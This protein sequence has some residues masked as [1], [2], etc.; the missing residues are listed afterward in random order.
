M[1]S[2]VNHAALHAW[3]A[4]S[5]SIVLTISVALVT[6]TLR[7]HRDDARTAEQL[8]VAVA[9]LAALCAGPVLLAAAVLLPDTWLWR[10]LRAGDERLRL[11]DALGAAVR[12]RFWEALA[13]AP[14]LPWRPQ[15]L[16]SLARPAKSAAASVGNAKDAAAASVGNAK[17]ASGEAAAG[18]VLA[19][20]ATSDWAGSRLQRLPD[21]GVGGGGG[22]GSTTAARPHGAAAARVPPPPSLT[23]RQRSVL[24][25]LTAGVAIAGDLPL[26]ATSIA[27]VMLA[28]DSLPSATAVDAAA[29]ASGGGGGASTSANSVTMNV[30]LPALSVLLSLWHLC[31][32]LVVV[33]GTGEG[34]SSAAGAKLFST[35]GLP[36][37]HLASAQEEGEGGAV[38]G[39]SGRFHVREQLREAGSLAQPTTAPARGAARQQRLRDPEIEGSERG[40]ELR[41]PD[42][43]DVGSSGGGSS[44][45]DS[46]QELSW[47]PRRHR[48]ATQLGIDGAG[49]SASPARLPRSPARAHDGGDEGATELRQGGQGQQHMLHSNAAAPPAAVETRNPLQQSQPQSQQ[50]PLAVEAAVLAVVEELRRTAAHSAAPRGGASS[51]AGAAAAAAAATGSSGGHGTFQRISEL[52]VRAATPEARRLAAMATFWSMH[53]A[54]LPAVS[55]A[56][57]QTPLPRVWLRLLHAL[58]ADAQQHGQRV[59][60]GATMESSSASSSGSGVDDSGADSELPPLSSSFGS[61][62]DSGYSSSLL[63]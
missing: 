45:S 9:A 19:H 20:D 44:Y 21:R 43:P 63:A 17:D 48:P 13:L 30:L 51:A 53:P 59:A 5:T 50:P 62:S 16:V 42:S 26:A 33:V 11:R 12:Y 39:D 23:L 35:G 38:A 10:R 2:V 49:R 15:L 57:A 36:A 55:D 29:A 28:R 52:W 58:E 41:A 8:G 22:V 54:L 31:T 32:A 24:R 61:G 56:L 60:G 14:I 6:A 40:L 1:S 18:V 27:W 47:T 4:I 34:G 37:L 46:E 3:S 7:S 25:A